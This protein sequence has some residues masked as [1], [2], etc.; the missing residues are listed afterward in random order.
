MDGVA[1]CTRASPPALPHLLENAAAEVHNGVDTAELLQNKQQA[2]HDN[3]L[4]VGRGQHPT[5]TPTRARAGG[6]L[7]ATCGMQPGTTCRWWSSV[8]THYFM[9]VVSVCLV[10]I[11]RAGETRAAHAYSSTMHHAPINNADNAPLPPLSWLAPAAP[12]SFT[13][14]ALASSRR[15]LDARYAGDS[16]QPTMPAAATP[17]AAMAAASWCGNALHHYLAWHYLAQGIR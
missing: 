15:P 2:A 5:S 16:G 10:G 3:A 8:Y 14:T 4:A 9:G 13:A 1:A 17:S 12:Q 11:T 7:G 6:R